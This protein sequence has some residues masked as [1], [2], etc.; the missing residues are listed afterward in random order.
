MGDDALDLGAAASRDNVNDPEIEL[1][2]ELKQRGMDAGCHVEL[3]VKQRV[4]DRLLAE[5]RADAG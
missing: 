1:R 2:H 4:H 3:F 5:D